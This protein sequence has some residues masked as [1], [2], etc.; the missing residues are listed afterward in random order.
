MKV[1]GLVA[2]IILSV[3][4]INQFIFKV[5]NNSEKVYFLTSDGKLY[6]IELKHLE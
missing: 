4:L 3:L 1:A 2:L 6:S 5:A